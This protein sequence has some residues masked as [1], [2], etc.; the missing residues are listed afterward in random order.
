M[1]VRRIFRVTAGFALGIALLIGFLVYQPVVNRGT[2]IEPPL[3]VSPERL[4]THVKR[5][6][7]EFV[8]RDS[9]FEK[10]ERAGADCQLH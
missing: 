6:S 3:E 1:S 9:K 8:P 5:L 10:S 7:T 2:S 4:R